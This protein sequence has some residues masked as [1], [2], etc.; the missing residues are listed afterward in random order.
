MVGGNVSETQSN[1]LKATDKRIKLIVS[2]KNLN[3]SSAPEIT[4]VI[5]H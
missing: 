3:F 5:H 4:V 2:I 1:W